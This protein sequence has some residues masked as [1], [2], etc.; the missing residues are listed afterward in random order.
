MCI[1]IAVQILLISSCL[2][3]IKPSQA[4][5]CQNTAGFTFTNVTCP[6]ET[7]CVFDNRYDQTDN[8][9][10]QPVL[11]QSVFGLPIGCCPNVLSTPCYPSRPFSGVVGCCPEFSS[12]CT[13]VQQG[14]EVLIGCASDREQCCGTRIC[15]E[16]YKCCDSIAGVC[17]PELL[18]CANRT[19]FIQNG[20]NTSCLVPYDQVYDGLSLISFNMTFNATDNRYE[21]NATFDPQ[22]YTFPQ[23]MNDTFPC[24]TERCFA[25]DTCAIGYANFT[26]IEVLSLPPGTPPSFTYFPSDTTFNLSFRE[27]SRELGCCPADS[28]PCGQQP[29][30]LG[31]YPAEYNYDATDGIIGCAGPDEECCAPYICP[32]AMKCCRSRA[33]FRGNLTNLIDFNF[34][35]IPTIRFQQM[36]CPVNVSTCCE[37]EVPSIFSNTNVGMIPYCGK[38]DSCEEPMFGIDSN[39]GLNGPIDGY[40][41]VEITLEE[42]SD[43]L[44]DR[45]LFFPNPRSLCFFDPSSQGLGC[46]ICAGDTAIPIDCAVPP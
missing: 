17:C 9:F 2:A 25:N 39:I 28:T 20:G 4:I 26:T 46:G 15:A 14:Q 38:G 30:G 7:Y 13:Q 37:V 34:T 32:P 40:E 8:L 11:T 18:R 12:C 45:R 10:S 21:F 16:G 29:V 5:E 33:T 42:Y 44:L 43:T 19:E 41:A 35:L 24:A 23:V 22:N 3:I 36:C 31:P 1:N 27:T 6:D